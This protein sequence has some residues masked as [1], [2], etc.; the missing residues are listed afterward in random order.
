MLCVFS[1]PSAIHLPKHLS[2]T[3]LQ[4][5]ASVLTSRAISSIPLA[6]SCWT[7]IPTVGLQPVVRA[8]VAFPRRCLAGPARQYPSPR[9]ASAGTKQGNEEGEGAAVHGR[10]GWV[11]FSIP[12]A[13]RILAGCDILLMPSRFE[14]CG[15]N[16]LFA[17]RYGTIPIAHATGG[18]RDT[19][20]T[21]ND[22]EEGMSS[23]LPAESSSPAASTAIHSAFILALHCQPGAA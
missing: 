5:H 18:L 22:S 3:W 17:M 9:N 13:H 20:Q 15:L 1:I 10:R 2:C 11:G 16:Q 12:V 21:Y 8:F 4:V 7:S 14:P 23:P 6:L 19:I